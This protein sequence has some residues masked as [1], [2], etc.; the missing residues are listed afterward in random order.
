ME[1]C[2]QVT[3]ASSSSGSIDIV[4][5]KSS[6][7][8]TDTSTRRGDA[9]SVESTIKV[10]PRL[11]LKN[12]SMEK[13]KSI[14]RA[15]SAEDTESMES[16]TNMES[17][18]ERA[19]RQRNLNTSMANMESIINTTKVDLAPDLRNT[20]TSMENTGKEVLDLDLRN[21]STSM[22]INIGRVDLD[23]RKKNTI[24]MEKNNQENGVTG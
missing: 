12:T 8:G 6:L 14:K 11:N 18:R 17:T 10:V 1:D 2:Q 5:S 13:R 4:L 9:T 19:P 7:E 24:N 16:M 3:S 20:S 23:Q 21:T 22:V 15:R